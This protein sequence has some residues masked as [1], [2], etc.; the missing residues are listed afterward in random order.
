MPDNLGNVLKIFSS[1]NAFCA[2][3][4]DRTITCWGSVNL[5]NMS[6]DL[7]DPYYA[8]VVEMYSTETSFVALQESGTIEIFGDDDTGGC[9]GEDQCPPR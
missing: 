5:E 4:I 7:L 8:R 9:N 6:D 2:L 3:H 1:F